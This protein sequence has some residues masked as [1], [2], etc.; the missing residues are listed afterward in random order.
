MAVG[1]VLNDRYRLDSMLGQGGMGAVWLGLDILLGRLVAVKTLH[2]ETP[3][4]SARFLR[5]A[6]TLAAVR[7]PGVVRVLDFG[8]A[9][10]G[11]VFMVMEYVA[12]LTLAGKL[13]T[14]PLTEPETLTLVASIAR[15]LSAVHAAGI[16]HRDVKPANIMLNPDGTVILVDFGIAVAQDGPKLTQSGALVG[17]PSYLAPEQAN[18]GPIT[19]ATDLYALG[20]VAYECL[21][22]RPPFDGPTP[23]AVVSKHLTEEPPQLPSSFSATAASLVGRALAKAPADRW[24][25]AVSMAQAADQDSATLPSTQP[26]PSKPSGRKRLMLIAGVM[27]LAA[28]AA[29]TVWVLPDADGNQTSQQPQA[30]PISTST[31]TATAPASASTTT[32]ATSA[33]P[34]V[35]DT[36]AWWQFNTTD[37]LAPDLVG[38]ATLGA[39]AERDGILTLDGLSGHVTAEVPALD[40]TKAFTIAVWA[41]FSGYGDAR[42]RD[43]TLA[44]IPGKNSSAFFLQYKSTWGANGWRFTMPRAD[45]PEPPVDAVASTIAPKPG[46]WYFVAGVHDPAAKRI[47]LYVDGRLQAAAQHVTAWKST[48]P[49]HLGAHLWAG[50]EGGHWPGALDKAAVY[51]RALTPGEI[52]ALGSW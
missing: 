35:P 23:M 50:L 8:T 13:A 12:G 40:P 14:G 5:E 37:A 52:K 27:T 9:S 29:I 24:P 1:Q 33:P 26:A 44:S 16:V 20:V 21:T 36:A 42:R 45:T 34:P 6:R 15:S 3:R 18:G 19:P 47:S 28:V 32:T 11:T 2:G 30:A 17:T 49:L 46:R 39:D 43:I 48:K 31:S 51:R 41:R 7:S 38:N 4:A 22:G 25:D 10:D